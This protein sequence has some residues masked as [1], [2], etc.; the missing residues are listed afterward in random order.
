M[1]RR[2]APCINIERLRSSTLSEVRRHSGAVLG[3]QH[4]HGPAVA[5]GVLECLT[6]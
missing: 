5:I 4:P 6:G 3:F 2:I 1:P